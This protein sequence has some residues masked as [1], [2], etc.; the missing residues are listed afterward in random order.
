MA[1]HGLCQRV[2]AAALKGGRAAQQLVLAHALGGQQIGELRL[3]GGDRPGL[4]ERDDVDPPRLLEGGGGLEQDALLRADA[5]AD[6][7]RDGRGK[8]QGAGAADDE[9]GDAAREGEAELT[10]E[11]QP[12]QRRHEGDRH[13]HRHEHAGNAVRDLRDRGLGRRR[14]RYHADDLAERRILADA[15]RLALQVA[16]AVDRRGRDAVAR[17]LVHGDALAGQGGFVH[18]ARPLENKAV[19][20]DALAR[21]H[22][23][24]VAPLHLLDGDGFLLPVYQQGRGLRR[25]LH[26]ALERVGGLALASGLQR[27]AHGDEREDHR[28]RLKVKFVHPGHGGVGTAREL[29]RRHREERVDAV[30]EARRRAEGD[31]GIH[32][33]RAV[34]QALE[35]ADKE[36][37]VYDHDDGREQQLDKA[38]GHVVAVKELRQ[39]PAPHRMPHRDIHQHQQEA[40]R[41]KQAALELRRLRVGEGVGL[42]RGGLL[43]ALWARA[44]ARG[45]DRTDDALGVRRA[46]HAHGVGE[47]AHRAGRDPRHRADRLLDPCRAGRAAHA[48]NVV[49]FHFE[50]PSI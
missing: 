36:F 23:K 33:R 2:L 39:R 13:D 29:R 43:R 49:L 10:T 47:Q 4:V 20:G 7:D 31:E 40:Q 38:H 35:A 9:H 5:A 27:L 34:Q 17:R 11:E 21:A 24:D 25:D 8:S 41:G 28:R 30:D 45:L 3:A 15:R 18:S 26:E 50:S 19:D 14:V 16:L 46:L 1:Q 22:H 32:V 48:G 37:L 42:R 12:H 44:V 6:H